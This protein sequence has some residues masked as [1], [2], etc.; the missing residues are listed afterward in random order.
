MLLIALFPGV[1]G[2]V[3]FT[4]SDETQP[5]HCWAYGYGILMRQAF[6]WTAV[7]WDIPC[8][9]AEQKVTRKVSHITFMCVMADSALLR[10]QACLDVDSWSLLLKRWVLHGGEIC[11]RW[12]NSDGLTDRPSPRPQPEGGRRPGASAASLIV[13]GIGKP[14]LTEPVNLIFQGNKILGSL[15]PKKDKQQLFALLPTISL[16]CKA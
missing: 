4:S 13:L 3:R 6:V 1:W 11:T 9:V 14:S 7:I 10:F 8:W 5:H 12:G 15:S 16:E 2:T